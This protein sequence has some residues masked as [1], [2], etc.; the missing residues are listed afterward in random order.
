MAGLRDVRDQARRG[1]L[2]GMVRTGATFADAAAEYL[3]YIGHDRGRKPSTLRGYRSN[4]EAH[5]LPEFGS[6]PVE[7]VTTERIE[8]WIAD[9]G[10]SARSRNKLLTEIH[11][12]TWVRRS[13]DRFH[14][15][16]IRPRASAS[17]TLDRP[18]LALRGWLLLSAHCSTRSQSAA[19]ATMQKHWSLPSMSSPAWSMRKQKIP[20]PALLPSDPRANPVQHEPLVAEAGA[21]ALAAASRCQVRIAVGGEGASR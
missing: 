1:T 8:N 19:R 2:P 5:L 6:L 18:E 4:I 16:S 13:H 15:L 11:D 12:I 9:Y 17:A 20:A 3:R 14:W 7:D 10:G 21:A